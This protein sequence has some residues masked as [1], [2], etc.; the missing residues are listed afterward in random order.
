MSS[1]AEMSECRTEV[2]AGIGCRMVVLRGVGDVVCEQYGAVRNLVLSGN[3]FLE[4][5]VRNINW[6][7]MC[8]V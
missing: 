8:E 6:T 2:Q 1:R 7:V 3:S 4:S 5:I